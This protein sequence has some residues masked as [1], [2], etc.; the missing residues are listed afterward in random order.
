MHILMEKMHKNKTSYQSIPAFLKVSIFLI[1]CMVMFSCSKSSPTN[2]T[3]LFPENVVTKKYF[4]QDGQ[5]K[6]GFEQ[7]PTSYAQY[8]P[9]EDGK[10]LMQYFIYEKGIN[11][12]F[13][14]SYVDYPESFTQG[15]VAVDILSDLLA[16]YIDTQKAGLETQKM[17]TVN[18]WPGIYFKAN[19]SDTYTFGEY[20]LR[21]NRLYQVTVTKE[22]NYPNEAEANS[23]FQ[24]LELL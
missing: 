3:K 10:V 24:S 6:I 8:I 4:N 1:S 18:S 14:I 17:I 22:S 2:K 23:F 21:K 12:I 13:C 9:H 19:N 11:L 20:I 5:F 15:K 7:E 16:T